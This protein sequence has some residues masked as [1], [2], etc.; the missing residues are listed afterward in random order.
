MGWGPTLQRPAVA[1][2]EHDVW[3][4]PCNVRETNPLTSPLPDRQHL[5]LECWF[6]LSCAI[7]AFASGESS[8]TVCVIANVGCTLRG[9]GLLAWL[10]GGHGRRLCCAGQGQ[11]CRV[12]CAQPRRISAV[13]IAER[14]AAERGETVGQDIG[15]SIRLE[16]KCEPSCAS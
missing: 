12:M 15:Y 2:V 8:K 6:D 7:A 4:T 1:S 11:G 9:L 3:K 14:V 13:S 16:S 5:S 10:L